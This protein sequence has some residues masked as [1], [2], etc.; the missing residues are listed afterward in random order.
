MAGNQPPPGPGGSIV[1]PFAPQGQPTQLGAPSGQFFANL[2]SILQTLNAILAQLRT[3]VPSLN[4]TQTYAFSSLPS[5]ATSPASVVFVSNAR[6]PGEGPGAG[7]G[8]LAYSDGTSWY[9]TAGP[10]LAD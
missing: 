3:G 6:K 4:N 1:Q 9:S 7:T 10:L 2:S 8:Q 5:A